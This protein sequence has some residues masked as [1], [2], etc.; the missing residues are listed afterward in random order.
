[1]GGGLFNIMK[2]LLY[3]ENSE[4]IGKSGI[5]K[6]LEHQMQALTVTGVEYTVDPEDDYDIL[7][8]NTWFLNSLNIISEAHKKGA[9]VIYH[10]HSTEEDFRNSFV[11]SNAVSKVVKQYFI[12]LYS[13]ADYIITP[14][15][16]SK[17]LLMGY[18]IKVP[19]EP[20]SNGVNINKFIKN[21][22]N[23][24]AFREYFNLKPEDKVVVSSGLW[25]KRKGILDFIATAKRMPDLKFIWFGQA[26][27]L[28]IPMEI[29]N[30]VLKDHPS[31]VIF[32]GYMTGPV[33]EGAFS[34]ADIFFFPS[35][36]ETEGIVVLEAMSCSGISLL[37]DIPVYDGWMVD[38]V[39]CF[40]GKS[41]DDF[42]LLLRK[43]LNKE[44]P[45]V[46]QAARKTAEERS[47][48]NV[49]KQLKSVYEKV[50]SDITLSRI[51]AYVRDNE[52][53]GKLNIGLF[54]DT[55]PPDVNGVSVSVDTLLR[56]LKK[57]GHNVYIITP[58][59][60]TKLVGTQFENGIL[61]MPAVKLKQLY[62]Y[63]LSRPYSLK[64]LEYIKKMHL[65]VLHI[66]T[67][68]SMRILANW[69]SVL[70]D[71]PYVYTYHTLYEDYTH[72]VTHGHM[73][74]TSKKIVGWYTKHIA[75]KTGE[76]IVPSEKTRRILAS[77]GIEKY[78]H[79]I[80]TG[81]DVKRF[82]PS[83]LDIQ[84]ALELKKNTGIENKFC[85]C[86]V[87][88]LATEKNVDFIIAAMPE[89]IKSIPNIVFLITGYGP[90]FDDLKAQTE[91]LKL[92]EYIIFVGKQA[93]DEVQ[94]YYNMGN[95]FV[96]ASTS[97]TQG[98][99]YIEAMGAGLPVIA[100]YD[101]CL[102]SVLVEGET[103]YTFRDSTSFIDKVIK[104]YN[105][106]DEQKQFMYN[107]ALEKASEFSLESFGDRVVQVYYQAIHRNKM[108][109]TYRKVQK[110]EK[111]ENY[112]QNRQKKLRHRLILKQE[113][114]DL[115]SEKKRIKLKI[116]N[117]DES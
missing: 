72:Y 105:D 6:A 18:G 36:E 55:F 74:G 96:T 58:S 46:R 60:E 10:A 7:H 15:P 77:Y 102:E 115:K 44:V 14:T 116:K 104:Y 19:I 26:N 45:D 5:G 47:I 53:V 95:V 50:L 68:F 11:F 29:R 82:N 63:R 33:Y 49:G 100:R 81:I 99:T 39:N 94:Y 42:V 38:N 101:D 111:A 75:E 9:R 92:N 28:S 54:S 108:K 70:F 12:N 31:N 87:G 114:L 40:K 109:K 64:A 2:V 32:P 8:I 24:K 84:R 4:H 37:R 67:E 90:S 88:R 41:V 93:P 66:N 86:Y 48:E 35:Y 69:V 21:P 52:K 20:V 89:L 25:I 97:E 103:G 73:E 22:E 3:F 107:K 112:K 113:K 62:G 76:I 59:L 30:A 61:R 98:L 34:S 71:I 43:I 51:E 79:I 13:K 106:T 23:E 91:L 83:N 17:K 117:N 85:I 56:Q 27:L 1:M 80:P 65:D 78:M 57:M 110:V 16:Y